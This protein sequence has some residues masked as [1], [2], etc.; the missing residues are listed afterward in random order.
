MAENE[1]EFNVTDFLR[2]FIIRWPI[3]LA[4][5]ALLALV[6]AFSALAGDGVYEA[7]GTIQIPERGGGL[8]LVGEFFT[9]GSGGAQIT[10]ELE[11]ISSRTIALSIIDQLDLDIRITDVT[12]GS[13]FTKAFGYLTSDGRQR[14][15]RQIRISDAEFSSAVIDNSYVLEYTDDSGSFSLT[16]PSGNLGSGRLGEPFESEEI[17]FTVT[18]MKGDTGTRFELKPKSL[19]DSLVSYNETFRA[20]SLGGATRTNLIS[21]TYRSNNPDLASDVINA[22]IGE[23]ERINREWMVSQG[24]VQTE[25]IQE[26]LADATEDL[27]D[28]QNAYLAYKAE[29]GIVML[30]EE[31]SITVRDLASREAEKVDVDLRLSLFRSIYNDLASSLNSDTFSVPPA[32]TGDQII[33]QL[34]GEHARLMVELENLLLDY[35]ENHPNVISKRESIRQVRQNI[36]D[37]V[38]S[39]IEGLQ[40]QRSDIMGVISGIEEDLYN[41]PGVESEL[42]ELQRGL[43][44]ADQAYRTLTRRLE[45]ARLVEGSYNVGNRVVDYA[46]PPAKPTAPSIRRNGALGLGLGLFL[47]LLLAFLFEA[48]DRR[49]VRSDQVE[50]VTGNIPVVRV[51]GPDDKN[52]IKKAAGLLAYIVTRAEDPGVSVLVPGVDSARL[53]ATIENISLMLSEGIS[54]MLLVDASP[55]GREENFFGL[56]SG[57][58]ISGMASGVSVEPAVHPDGRIR[59]ITPG[60]SPSGTHI[61]NTSVRN[62][63]N[64]L[65]EEMGISIYYAP[66]IAGEP[67]LMGWSKLSGSTVMVIQRASDRIDQ[68]KEIV[69]AMSSDDMPVNAVILL[70]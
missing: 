7:N 4:C 31:A 1:R 8:G 36:L 22:V 18:S 47:G 51:T 64:T 38:S 48:F 58:G 69:K 10:S 21:V 63:I 35:T 24:S 12:Y 68:L 62:R 42:L 15:L 52:G 11:I 53:R 32:L 9:I 29:H 59:L 6:L 55:S 19:H 61:A 57:D 54:P 34:A 39:T 5:T 16:G 33:Q 46:I 45:E 26:H 49:V 2:L 70:D 56:E 30:P 65:S 17:S 27:E 40:E 13:P 14:G 50:R 28:A 37:A 25:I 44:V 60:S 41:I 3:V 43:D 23:Y 20:S 66:G 67:S